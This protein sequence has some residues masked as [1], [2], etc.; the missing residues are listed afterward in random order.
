[1]ASPSPSV[2]E[3]LQQLILG[4]QRIMEM[5]DDVVGQSTTTD[6]RLEE[7]SKRVNDI[8]LSQSMAVNPSSVK[9]EVSNPLISKASS[10]SNSETDDTE[11]S[12]VN[13]GNEEDLAAFL[14]AAS[15]TPI[16]TKRRSAPD[17]KG[18]RDSYFIRQLDADESDTTIKYHTKAPEQP[19][20][21]KKIK[22]RDVLQHLEALLDYE[23][24]Y[25]IKLPLERTISQSCIDQIQSRF[26]ISPQQFHTS[27]LSQILS[28]LSTI[29]TPSTRQE[30]T[31]FLTMYSSS[32]CN[33]TKV[34]T[35]SNISYFVHSLQEHR[36]RLVRLLEFISFD[37]RAVLV[38][39]LDNFKKDPPGLWLIIQNSLP[40]SWLKNCLDQHDPSRKNIKTTK[41]LFSYI[42]LQCKLLKDQEIEAKQID[43]MFTGTPADQQRMDVSAARDPARPN[44]HAITEPSSQQE[45]SYQDY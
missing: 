44:I 29:C 35:A 11:S 38:M 34:P 45:Y 19:E 22:Y 14:D 21:L 36:R 32:L 40:F 9:E 1:M 2:E 12:I 43:N 4:Q 8:E 41:D 33:V 16:L 7:M 23:H 15:G 6:T 30:M 3:M 26:N 5:I 31:T 18:L 27:S 37:P 42:K 13:P 10:P 25:R 28:Y 17:N 24:K 39:P 20:L